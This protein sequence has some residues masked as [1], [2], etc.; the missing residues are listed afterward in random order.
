MTNRQM[1]RE[2]KKPGRIY[3]PVISSADVIHILVQKLDLIELLMERDPE[4]KCDWDFFGAYADG[5]K[6]DINS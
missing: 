4:G 6:L 5:R 2:L 3:M 1:I